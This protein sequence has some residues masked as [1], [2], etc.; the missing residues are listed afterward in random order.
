M[1]KDKRNQD[2]RLEDLRSVSLTIDN[3]TYRLKDLSPAGFSFITGDPN[4]FK[5]GEI[6][7]PITL[8]F[9]LHNDVIVGKIVHI[10]SMPD[11]RNRWIVGLK[12]LFSEDEREYF[13]ELLKQIG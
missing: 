12:F 3:E 2:R 10:T 5:V 8:G 13:N 4:D 6:L 7:S 11:S 1:R 9:D